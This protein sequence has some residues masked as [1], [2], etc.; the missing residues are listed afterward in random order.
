[1]IGSLLLF[2]IAEPV[3]PPC[4]QPTTM[5][6]TISPGSSCCESA[7]GV[8]VCVGRNL[9]EDYKYFVP[10]LSK[11]RVQAWKDSVIIADSLTRIEEAKEDADAIA[12]EKRDDKRLR[13]K[14]GK[15]V[16]N[17]VEKGTV[18]IGMTSEQ[19]RRSWGE[20]SDINRTINASGTSE[21]WVYD[22][23]Y[24]YFQDGILTTIQN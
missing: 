19:A 17:A 11:E 2:L 16:W 5:F 1:M 23:A 7:P 18:F 10:E 15:K 3:I 14:W 9:R 4:T 12:K 8:K 13:A 20:P 6:G 22:G 24:L 21:Q